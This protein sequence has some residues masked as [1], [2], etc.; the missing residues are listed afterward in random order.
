MLHSPW[1]QSALL[2]FRNSDRQSRKW[3]A[4]IPEFLQGGFQIRPVLSQ[5]R[6]FDSLDAVDAQISLQIQIHIDGTLWV[7]GFFGDHL[8]Q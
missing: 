8:D 6:R 2:S 3:F 4:G 1:E 7:T 5:C